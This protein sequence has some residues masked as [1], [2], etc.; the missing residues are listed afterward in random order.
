MKGENPYG[1]IRDTRYPFPTSRPRMSMR[2]RAAQ[3]SPFSALTG[4]DEIISRT[5]ARSAKQ[6]END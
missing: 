3:F 2:D 1:D 6:R 5:M 4:Y